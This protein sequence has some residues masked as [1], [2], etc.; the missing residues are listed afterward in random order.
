MAILNYFKNY[1][2]LSESI[3]KTLTV[4]SN[5]ATAINRPFGL[6]LID[7]TSLSNLSVLEWLKLSLFLRI[8]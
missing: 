2:T 6:I 4:V 5:R 7:K 3:K 1:F 8:L